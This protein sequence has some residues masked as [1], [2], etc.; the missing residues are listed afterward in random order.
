MLVKVAVFP[1]LTNDRWIKLY[2]PSTQKMSTIVSERFVRKLNGASPCLSKTGK[3]CF[4][5]GLVVDDDNQQLYYTFQAKVG[6]GTSS[7]G[8]QDPGVTQIRMRPFSGGD[9]DDIVRY[10][11]FIYEYLDFG[12]TV[13]SL[14]ADLT[15]SQFYVSMHKGNPN[16]KTIA[17]LPM[18]RSSKTPL[19]A[20]F[21]G[22]SNRYGIST[23]MDDS[24]C[25][26][27]GLGEELLVGNRPAVDNT[28]YRFKTGYTANYAPRRGGES[29]G[30]GWLVSVTRSLGSLAVVPRKILGGII[31]IIF[32]VFFIFMRYL[33]LCLCFFYLYVYII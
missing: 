28:Y 4:I 27:G 22:F 20:C 11:N 31:G 30:Q 13:D 33:F 10:R 23:S 5:L 25:R 32:P 7:S 29:G 2:D 3:G 1:A 14:T 9:G 15:H 8:K 24:A 17:K 21:K 18:M 12:M 26:Q 19:V 16:G 6:T